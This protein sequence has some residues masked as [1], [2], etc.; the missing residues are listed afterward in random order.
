[1]A[2]CKVCGE[3][4]TNGIVL[5]SKCW[6]V[7]MRTD[8]FSAKYPPAAI[9][10]GRSEE[11]DYEWTYSDEV[12]LYNEEDGVQIGILVVEP[13]A[14]TWLLRNG[15]VMEAMYWMPLPFPPPKEVQ[16]WNA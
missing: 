3:P 9:H 14:T 11:E 15:N 6:D 2:K 5:H 7:L 13:T 16:A 10:K 8:W 1:M 4:V 12:L